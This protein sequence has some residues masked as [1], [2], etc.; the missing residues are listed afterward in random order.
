MY[1]KRHRKSEIFFNFQSTNIFF[2][3][4]LATA[5]NRL[6]VA[7]SL[8]SNDQEDCENM[9]LLLIIVQIF[10]VPDTRN[11]LHQIQD[12]G[13]NE[14]ASPFCTQRFFRRKRDKED[15]ASFIEN[16][17]R[18]VKV[19]LAKNQIVVCFSIVVENFDILQFFPEQTT[20]SRSGTDRDKIRS[21]GGLP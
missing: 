4:R 10:I 8:V 1:K 7:T 13:S 15:V 14:F 3:G 2:V 21:F 5:Q 19:E 16:E 6:H 11:S 17:L 12:D 20:E 9:L 18:G